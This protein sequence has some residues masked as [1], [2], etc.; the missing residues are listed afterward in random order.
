[1]EVDAFVLLPDDDH[2]FSTRWRQIKSYFTRNCQTTFER[3][4]ATSRKTKQERAFWQRRFWEHSSFHRNRQRII[5]NHSVHRHL[6]IE[7]RTYDETI[8]R[9]I[10]GYETMLA[11]AA[12]EIARTTPGLTLDLGGGTGA[13]SEAILSAD[14]SGTVELIDIDPEML[15]QARTRLERF[16]GRVRF[17]ESSFNM[18]LPPCK[19]VAASLALHHVPTMD[20]KRALYRRIYDALRSGGAF[21]NADATMP[22]APPEREATWRNWIDHMVA[23]GIDEPRARE[24]FTQWAEEDTYFPLEEELEAARAAGFD[25]ECVWQQGPVAVVVA[26]IS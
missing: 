11:V 19:A 3:A 15:V 13:L 1:M 10:P 23:R 12:R 18:P 21:V 4:A 22:A 8:R 25:A 20:A 6:G 24:Y 17:T 5:M 2:D 7:I 9:F 14:G 26:R 16:D